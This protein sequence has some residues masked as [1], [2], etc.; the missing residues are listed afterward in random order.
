VYN[1]NFFT[2]DSHVVISFSKTKTS[3]IMA[4]PQMI[5]VPISEWG[6]MVSIDLNKL[7]QIPASERVEVTLSFPKDLIY[8]GKDGAI[9]LNLA[10]QPSDQDFAKASFKPQWSKEAREKI[11]AAVDS[12]KAQWSTFTPFVGNIKRSKFEQE[13]TTSAPATPAFEGAPADNE[14]LPF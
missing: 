3:S 6:D 11:K 12:G 1:K 14:D 8:Q 5:Q 7:A 10:V 4:K 13:A 2:Q 9:Y